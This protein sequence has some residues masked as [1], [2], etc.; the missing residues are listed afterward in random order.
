MHVV[1]S[2]FIYLFFLLAC[3]YCLIFQIKDTTDSR[4][5]GT[6]NNTSSRGGARAGTDRYVGRGG[7]SATQFSSSGTWIMFVAI[8][9][10][11]LR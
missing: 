4:S 7:S 8:F 11:C 10:K 6:N 1:K 2:L 5:R 9:D 3:A